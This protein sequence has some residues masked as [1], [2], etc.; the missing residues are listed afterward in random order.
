MKINDSL[1]ADSSMKIG[2]VFLSCLIT[3]YY[4]QILL[5]LESNGFAC[6]ATFVSA[7]RRKMKPI[8]ITANVA[9]GAQ[10][11]DCLEISFY[12]YLFLDRTQD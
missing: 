5:G 7:N 12:G 10:L 8:N 6:Q 2:A 1:S 11:A 4:Y 9:I 3:W